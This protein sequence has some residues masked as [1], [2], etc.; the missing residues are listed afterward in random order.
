MTASTTAVAAALAAGAA[1][2]LLLEPAGVP[3]R[4]A[5]PSP[6]QGTTRMVRLRQVVGALVGVTVVVWTPAPMGPVIGVAVGL[7]TAWLGRRWGTTV[8]RAVVDAPTGDGVALAADLVVAAV[9]SGVAVTV[10]MEAVGAAVGG[11]VGAALSASARLDRAGAP[12][13]AAYRPLLEREETARMGR[14]L[15][16]ARGSGASPLPVLDRAARAERERRRSARVSRAR[17]AGS[18]AAVPV[19]VLFLPA[20]V[21]VAVV[22]LVVGA[23]GPVL[24]L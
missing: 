13:D 2:V 16:A 6:P 9:G 21:L 24:G 12:S 15:V 19:G 3:H 11:P 23:I 10:A 17:G 22:P 5:R 8:D 4:P 18:L 14:A 7:G 20:F 1:V